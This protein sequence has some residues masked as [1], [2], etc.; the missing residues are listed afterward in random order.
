MFQVRN[1]VPECPK[2]PVA[3][4]TEE[5]PHFSSTVVVVNVWEI[6]LFLPEGGTAYLAS[7]ILF[8]KHALFVFKSDAIHRLDAVPVLLG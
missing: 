2:S 8:D 5:A 1:I 7:I 6:F 3:V 4:I